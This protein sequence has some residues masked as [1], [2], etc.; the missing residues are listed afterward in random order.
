MRIL[1]LLALSMLMPAVS[2]AQGKKPAEQKPKNESSPTLKK[3]QDGANQALDGVEKGV[4]E[5]AK[6]LSAGANKALQSVDDTIHG[7]K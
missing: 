3:A 5:G 2:S 7:R 4:K 1:P 6:A